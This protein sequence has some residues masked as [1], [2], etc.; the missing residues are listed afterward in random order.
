MNP[1]RSRHNVVVVGG[2]VAGSATAMMLARL[3]QLTE[4]LRHARRTSPVQGMLRMPNQV[5]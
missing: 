3:G 4:R 2:R 1:N 5:R